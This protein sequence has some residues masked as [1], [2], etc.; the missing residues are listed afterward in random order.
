LPPPGLLIAAAFALNAIDGLEAA[1][2]LVLPAQRAHATRAAANVLGEPVAYDDE[3][4]PRLFDALP[5]L[6]VS[7]GHLD[8]DR[9]IV[10]LDPGLGQGAR[11]LGAH[12][13]PPS[14]SCSRVACVTRRT[15]EPSGRLTI[16]PCR[17]PTR[18]RLV[19]VP[20]LST[21][22]ASSVSSGVTSS[23]SD[24]CPRLGGSAMMTR[25]VRTSVPSRCSTAPSRGPPLSVQM[26]RRAQSV[27]MV[28]S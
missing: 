24:L 9:Y 13:V 26:I 16:V 10:A 2:S 18:Y 15:A 27:G 8:R 23:A 5:E 1:T 3:A 28:F 25:P 12:R 19:G 7:A 17:K 22:G 4:A 21:S 20:T 6:P 14:G 11:H